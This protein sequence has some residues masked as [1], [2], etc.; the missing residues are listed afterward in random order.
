MQIQPDYT[1]EGVAAIFSPFKRP[2]DAEHLFQGLRKA[3]LPQRN[4][5][6]LLRFRVMTYWSAR[7][8]R[9]AGVPR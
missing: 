9:A 7:V 2:E 8:E 3:G 5:A 1:I 4:D 6:S